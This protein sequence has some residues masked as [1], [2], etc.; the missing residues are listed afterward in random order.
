MRHYSSTSGGAFLII[1][2]ARTYAATGISL[3]RSALHDGIVNVNGKLVVFFV[4]L[5]A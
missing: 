1:S 4:I 5:G 2:P 3:C